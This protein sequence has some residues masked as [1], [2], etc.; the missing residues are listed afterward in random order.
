MTIR[1]CHNLTIALIIALLL[2][3]QS[4]F[5]DAGTEVESHGHYSV[6]DRAFADTGTEDSS[7]GQPHYIAV[8]S[9]RHNTPDAI[10]VAMSSMPDSV[11]YVCLNGDMTDSV[12][13]GSAG[14][15]T[16]ASPFV[17]TGGSTGASSSGSSSDAGSRARSEMPYN[18]SEVLGEVQ[19]V[20]PSLD[21]SRISIVYGAH[22]ANAT[23]DVGIMKCADTGMLPNGADTDEISEGKSGLI[24]TGY[25]GTEP[26]FYVYGVSYCD[27]MN[28][29]SAKKASKAF[30]A[31]ADSEAVDQDAPIIAIG[32]VPLHA[33]RNDNLGAS[34]WNDA[35]N[36]AAAADS[37]A[38]A[39]TKAGGTE[40]SASASAKAEATDPSTLNTPPTIKREVAYLH[41]H[42]HTVEKTEYYV[43]PGET[44]D[45]QG[46][47]SGESSESTILYTYM[48]GGYLRDNHTASLVG[49][50]DGHLFFEKYKSC[51]VSFET[52]SDSRPGRVGVLQGKSI[53]EPAA[54][55]RE[56]YV[57][58]GWYTEAACENAWNFSKAV[59]EDMT[60][61]A[62]WVKGVRPGAPAISATMN[63]KAKKTVLKWTATA[64]AADYRVAYRKAGSKT[65]TRRW[66]NGKTQYT[67]SGLAKGGLY[68][69]KVSAAA[70]SGDRFIY[71]ADSNVSF[72]YI[73]T[74]SKVRAKAGK[75][76]IKLSW[77]KDGKASLCRIQYAANRKMKNA[78]TI[79]VAGSKKTCVIR[80]LKKGKTYYV[81]VMPL[82]KKSG[83]VYSGAWSPR[84][85]VTTQAQGDR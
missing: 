43:R 59:D 53:A 33:K 20:F 60:L 47:A 6:E 42:N 14:G 82:V 23:D 52:N 18:T 75:K 58:T 70:E 50:E 36:H 7:G 31:W 10:E 56:G 39:G 40:L 21:A 62:G 78:K 17:S 68:E 1:T 74:L 35:L 73:S 26:A 49:V 79:T 61:Y 15:S 83:N 69:F 64:N 25:D 57:F 27:T 85:A 44:L 65:W 63:P 29:A 30:E 41:G 11:E 19:D 16:G 2:L 67:A 76:A 5:A 77:K 55:V 45:V 38:L 3:G 9:D 28:A 37:G 81:R 8:S 12:R 34:Y 71:S 24:Y 22:D 4:A 32:H 13:S 54:P 84:R 46:T 48:T 72:R 51:A 80:N 66:T